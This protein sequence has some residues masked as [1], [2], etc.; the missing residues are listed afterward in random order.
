[1]LTDLL[2]DADPRPA[3]T[4]AG[5]A[6]LSQVVHD[7]LARQVVRQ[8]LATVA[9]TRLRLA[10]VPLVP[11]HPCPPG[12]AALRALAEVQPQGWSR[13]CRNC[14]LSAR[15]RRT[16]PRSWRTRPCRVATSVGS[17]ASG[18]ASRTSLPQVWDTLRPRA[19][20]AARTKRSW[21]R[22]RMGGPV[23]A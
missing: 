11:R 7:P 19:S 10:S 9:G 18:L 2:A 14:S 16:S 12:T 23:H 1:L 20:G 5:L 21:H 4:G 8:R 17:G 15:R 13:R 22:D 3:A 6:R